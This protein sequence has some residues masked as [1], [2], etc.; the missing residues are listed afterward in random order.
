MICLFL[1]V[2]ILLCI[3]FYYLFFIKKRIKYA[4]SIIY[5]NKQINL[6]TDKNDPSTPFTKERFMYIFDVLNNIVLYCYTNNYPDKE[7]SELLYKRWK[8]VYIS[9]MFPYEKSVAFVVNKDT[10]LKI[11]IRKPSPTFELEDIN[12]TIFV[13]LHELSHMMC[14]SYGHN[15]EFNA[16]F[17]NI[18]KVARLLLV[19][20]PIH[21]STSPY[22]Y[23]H[24]LI[25]TSPC[26]DDHK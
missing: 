20:K 22:K 7:H 17:L 4:S 2:I 8:R 6:I 14:L 11:R 26:P 21:Y 9:E 24:I 19:Y 13:C 15:D 5:K 1:I 25:E 10:E 3:F 12:P 23:N 16:I 18:I